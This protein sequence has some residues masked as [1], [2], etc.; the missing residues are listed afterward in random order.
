M[1]K[2]IVITSFNIDSH[3]VVIFDFVAE[4]EGELNLK[5]GDTLTVTNR[6]DDGWWEGEC[7]GQRGLFPS[8]YVAK[9]LE[10]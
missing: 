4:N 6:F 5:L 9:S 1:L 10:K 7:K 2:A 8:N 3:F